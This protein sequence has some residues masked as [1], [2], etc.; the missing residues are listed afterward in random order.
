MILLTKLDSLHRCL[1]R[2]A[3][4]APARVEA[5]QQDPDIQDIITLNLERVVQVCVDIAAHI[6]AEFSTPP[7]S[8][9]AES[10]DRLLEVG[11]ISEKTA[12]RMKKAVGFRN[13]A[14]HEYQKIDWLIVY[15]ITTEH[16]DD[17]KEFAR[18]ALDWADRKKKSS[19]TDH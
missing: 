7:P 18:E 11:V 14:V 10:F 17:F 8:A 6:L 19:V 4:K 9:M 13:V 2:V 12:L 3:F 5:L 1:S 16:L 15:R